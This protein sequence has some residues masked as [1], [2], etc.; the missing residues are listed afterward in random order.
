M[1]GRRALRLGKVI[2]CDGVLSFFAAKCLNPS[3]WLLWWVFAMA[4]CAGVLGG[5]VPEI[6]N[7]KAARTLNVGVPA[8]RELSLRY[9]SFGFG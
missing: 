5:L 6:R 2:L 7:Y 3:E 4:V 1:N 9:L 8:I